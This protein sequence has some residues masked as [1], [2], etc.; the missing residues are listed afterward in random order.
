[1]SA[2]AR[3]TVVAAVES[4]SEDFTHTW[5]LLLPCARWVVSHAELPPL[6]VACGRT[7]EIRQPRPVRQEH[8]F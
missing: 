6:T 7:C 1:M 5:R 2:M 3:C 8:D 4:H